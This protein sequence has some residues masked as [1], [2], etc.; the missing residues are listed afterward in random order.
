MRTIVSVLLCCVGAFRL[1]TS[2]SGGTRPATL[3]V[4]NLLITISDFWQVYTCVETIHEGGLLPCNGQAK[5]FRWDLSAATVRASNCDFG[6]PAR[7]YGMGG[8]VS[9]GAELR[10]ADMIVGMI[11]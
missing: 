6:A 10:I 11:Y 4:I 9:S 5:S 7:L 2:G 3:R 8:R 1:S